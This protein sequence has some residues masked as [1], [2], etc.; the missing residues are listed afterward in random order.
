MMLSSELILAPLNGESGL[1]LASRYQDQ[2]QSAFESQLAAQQAALDARGEATTTEGQQENAAIQ[3]GFAIQNYLLLSAMLNPSPANIEAL[4][5]AYANTALS[6]AL[7]QGQS[8][9]TG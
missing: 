2:V 1:T 4:N 3:Q 6:D 8:S 5:K 7:A 9:T